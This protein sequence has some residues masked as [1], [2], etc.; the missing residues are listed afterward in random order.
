MTTHPEENPKIS[1]QRNIKKNHPLLESL[2][3]A[4]NDYVKIL[5]PHLNSHQLQ[6]LGELLDFLFWEDLNPK[7]ANTHQAHPDLALD[8]FSG[9]DPDQDAEAFVR[10]IKCNVNFALGTE[11]DEA[12]ANILSIFSDRKLY[13]PHCQEDQQLNGMGAP[14]KKLWLGTMSEPYL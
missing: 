4:L 2:S 8:K 6:F 1:I 5:E 14:S 12:D 3:Q 9:T 13:F 10:I 11:P 7:M